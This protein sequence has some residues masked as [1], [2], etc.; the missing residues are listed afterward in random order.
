VL[1][2]KNLIKH[3]K[4]FAIYPPIM[5]EAPLTGG[6][7]TQNETLVQRF[8]NTVHSALLQILSCLSEYDTRVS[9]NQF[10]HLHRP[11]QP[12]RTNL[13]LLK[14]PSDAAADAV[15]HN[16]HTDL[17][18]LTFLLAGQWGLQVL[19]PDENCWK[20][21]APSSRHAVIN[22]GD[23]LRFL[24]HNK[25][26]SVVHRVVPINDGR[27]EDRYSIG[28]FL[29]PEDEVE[30]HNSDGTVVTAKAWHE[31]RMNKKNRRF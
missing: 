10:V 30:C 19:D 3:Q 9:Q 7:V 17:G 12:S 16:E 21:V 8:Q 11:S 13:A 20:Y 23:S 4:Q 27:K 5:S 31:I 25:F 28:F 14:Y 1:R 29:R 18:S 24:S 6:L 22:V 26:L 15:G 2:S